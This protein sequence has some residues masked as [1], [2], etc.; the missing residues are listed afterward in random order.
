MIVE[1]ERLPR[2][3]DVFGP[4]RFSNTRVRHPMVGNLVHITLWVVCT[5]F[6]ALVECCV[7]VEEVREETAGCHLTGKL[8][9]IVVAV[10]RQIT[11]ASF[12]FS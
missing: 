3:I 10:F 1:K 12:H 6:F 11:Y 8:V 4:K 9:K 7:E 2:P 5:P